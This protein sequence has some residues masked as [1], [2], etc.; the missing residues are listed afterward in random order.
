MSFSQMVSVPSK[1]INV[2]FSFRHFWKSEYQPCSS[3]L[4][5]PQAWEWPT[6]YAECKE[7]LFVGW[8]V[9]VWCTL[10]LEIEN[11]GLLSVG[12]KSDQ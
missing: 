11:I 6:G 8:G 3:C 5:S 9:V 7:D 10:L 12:I 2:W 4:P 1:P